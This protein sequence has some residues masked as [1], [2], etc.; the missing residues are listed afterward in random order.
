LC[1]A[2]KADKFLSILIKY[3]QIYCTSDSIGLLH[4]SVINQNTDLLKALIDQKVNVDYPSMGGLT[5]L[6]LCPSAQIMELLLTANAQINAT[7]PNG[8]TPLHLHAC[9]GNL[10]LVSV[11]ISAK[12]NVNQFNTAGITPLHMTRP[13]KWEIHNLLLSAK[14]DI[15]SRHPE[16][17]KTILHTVCENSITPVQLSTLLSYN[18]DPNKKD[19]N[20]RTPLHLVSTSTYKLD[21]VE[22]LVE[23]GANINASNKE[24]V[25]PILRAIETRA[26]EIWRFLVESG[27][28]TNVIHPLS[29]KTGHALACELFW[30]IG[31]RSEDSIFVRGKKKKRSY[32]GSESE[33]SETTSEPL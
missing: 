13:T 31:D 4:K 12:A 10:H 1:N 3:Q 26:K 25:T 18:A 20:G 19:K 23:N 17:L 15:H 22:M 2:L 33:E 7:D 8:N 9:Q 32:S 28:D 27:A 29:G 30:K 5:P 14:A 6:H 11:L 21:I 24:G 16:S